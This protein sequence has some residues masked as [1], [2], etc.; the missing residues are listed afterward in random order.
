MEQS[1]SQRDPDHLQAKLDSNSKTENAGQ[2]SNSLAK[3]EAED[4]DELFKPANPEEASSQPHEKSED[5]YD[6]LIQ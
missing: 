2:L 5:D 1:Q 3:G 6:F 4:D